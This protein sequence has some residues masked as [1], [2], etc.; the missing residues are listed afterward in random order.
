MHRKLS[1]SVGRRLAVLA[2]IGALSSVALGGVA[3]TGLSGVQHANE[4]LRVLQSAQTLLL[5]LD[6]RS[7]ELKVDGYKAAV[8]PDPKEG[9]A[10][11]AEDIETP[12]ALLAEL[13]A[14]PLPA[15]MAEWTAKVDTAYN[16]YFAGISTYVDAAI[17]NQA[18][19]RSRFQEIQTANDGIDDI[20]GETIDAAQA[21]EE[22]TEAAL[23]AR[24]ARVQLLTAVVCLLGLASLA[25]VA[26]LVTRSITVPLGRVRTA[27]EALA[28]RDLTHDAGVDSQDELGDMAR[29]LGLAQEALRE[30][31]GTLADSSD[32]V[33][34]AADEVSRNVQTVAAGAEQM[35]ASIREIA[36]NTGEAARVGETAMGIAEAT[37]AT[38]ARLGDSS[39]EIGEVIKVITSIA[40][41][42]NLLALN[43]TIEAARAGEAGKGFAVVANEVKDLAQETAKATE[44]IGRRVDAI[45]SDTEGAVAAI[46]EIAGVI[47]QMNDYQTTIASAVEEQTATTQEM[48]RNVADAAGA[49]SQI[50]ANVEGVAASAQATS[51]G[52]GDTESAAGDL[53][54]MG[55]DLQRLVSTFR[56]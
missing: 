27:L 25:A 34:A 31:V 17:A 13:Q 1:L 26:V 30:T 49:S 46:A 22:S 7:S 45:Q 55:S 16:A 56:V 6:T 10:E 11:L 15:D 28:Q 33:A 29:S 36:V 44:D 23:A 38:V 9:L 48:S 42:T 39:R 18:V 5:R 47:A 50:A 4:E 53:A 41:Q 35:G 37:N 43:A 54:R 8:R 32:A 3:L 24:I 20:L 12:K 40:A 2:G 19:A 14:L 51:S 52:V 21:L